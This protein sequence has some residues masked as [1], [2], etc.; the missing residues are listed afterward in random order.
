MFTKSFI[1]V[2]ALAILLTFTTAL[3]QKTSNEAAK[4]PRYLIT[5]TQA[6]KTLGEIVVEL[7]PDIA[8]LH[9]ANFDSL[10]AIK[11]FDGCAFHRVIPGFM[12]QGGDPNSKDKPKNT[13]GMGDPSQAT[14]KAEFNKTKHVRG[15]LSAARSNDPNSATSQFFIMVADKP[16]LDGQYSAYGHVVSGMETADAIV[17]SLRDARDNPIEKIEMK[18][19][20]MEPAKIEPKK[21][22]KKKPEKNKPAKKK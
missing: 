3:A 7:H 14:V 9:C 8:P 2:I 18:I 4:G 10:V 21:D 15:I 1:S 6:G 5:V 11:F 22:A 17:N 19:V 20:K 13:W 12:I 16:H